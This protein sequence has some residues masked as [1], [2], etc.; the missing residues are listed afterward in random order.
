[1]F[2]HIW[3]NFMVWW[4]FAI[5]GTCVKLKLEQKCQ[6]QNSAYILKSPWKKADWGK[7]YCLH[8]FPSLLKHPFKNH[9][10]VRS[11][12]KSVFIGKNKQTKTIKQTKN[13]NKKHKIEKKCRFL[14]ATNLIFCF[15]ALY[16]IMLT[17]SFFCPN[18]KDFP[19]CWIRKVSLSV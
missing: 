6:L 11:T 7:E 14:C 5:C 17:L 4:S 2:L 1:M 12:P 18:V 13:N 8:W 16:I 9:R 3:F 15:L 10:L 19:W